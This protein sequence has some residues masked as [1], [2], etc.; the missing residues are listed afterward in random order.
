MT[1]LTINRIIEV[2]YSYSRD[3]HYKRLPLLQHTTYNAKD[4]SVFMG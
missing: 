2:W 3:K 1:S 4:I